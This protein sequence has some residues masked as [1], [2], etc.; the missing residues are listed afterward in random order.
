MTS[1]RS[2]HVAANDIILI[3]HYH[4]N[5]ETLGV[6]SCP[7]NLHRCY[8][9]HQ[10]ATWED[11]LYYRIDGDWDINLESILLPKGIECLQYH[12]HQRHCSKNWRDLEV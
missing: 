7:A 1:C 3:T 4:T 5:V 9:S 12:G 11:L 8:D 10:Y 2:I 6:K